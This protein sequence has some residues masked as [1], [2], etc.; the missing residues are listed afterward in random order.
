MKT[1]CVLLLVGISSFASPNRIHAGS[2]DVPVIRIRSGGDTAL[3]ADWRF[4][5]DSTIAAEGAGVDDSGWRLLDL[6]HDW[7]I[8]DLQDGPGGGSIGPFSKESPGGSSTGHTIGGVGWYRKHFSLRGAEGKVVSVLF[9][10]VYMDCDAWINGRHLGGHPYGYTPFFFDLTKGL[11]PEGEDNVLAVRVRNLGRN[12]RWYSGSGIYRHVFLTVKSPVHAARWGIAIST[13]EV[14]Q[15]RAVVTVKTTLENASAMEAKVVIR[16]RFLDPDGKKA[17]QCETRL[18]V[19][20]HGSAESV[21]TVAILKPRLWSP[22]T[23][24]LYRLDVE[25]LSNGKGADRTSQ[26]FGIRSVRFDAADGFLLNGRKTALRGAC[27]HHDNGPL[28]SAAIDRAEERRVEL[29]KAAGF[30]AVRTSH[31]PPSVPFL[32]ACD[33]LGMLVIDEAFDM[34][35][36]PKNPQDYH[37][38]F[39][40]WWQRDLEAMILRDRNHPSVILW[41]IGNE[42]NERADSSGIVIGRR[43][44][45][46]A[47]R[48][49]PTRAVTA[50]ICSFWDHPGR[51]WQDTESAFSIL[52]VGGYNY[53][54]REY[55]PDHE[56]SPQRIMVGT[57]SFPMEAFESWNPVEKNPW[58][59]GDFVW[60]GMDY[61]GEAGIGNVQ[62]VPDS[63]NPQFGMPWP[64]FN[65]FCG[66][67]DL[68]GFK[69]PQ[70]YY[71][72]VVWDR[73]SLEMAV[74]APMAE[75]LVEKPSL[76]GWPDERRS[77]TWP[78]L[79]AK[80]MKVSVYSRCPEVRLELN[81]EPVGEKRISPDSKWT[82]VF[83]VPYSP[84]ILRA[85][86]LVDGKEAVSR[87][88]RTAGPAHRIR[89]IPDRNVIRPD[90]ND[91]SYVTVEIVD[92]SGILVPDS[93]ALVR[94]SVQGDGELAAVGNGNP[95]DMRSFRKPECAVF[96]GKCLA[97]LRP[98]GVTGAIT[99]SA[100]SQGLDPASVVVK[101]R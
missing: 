29:L 59:I 95:R 97:I 34:W 72:D 19:P 99:L 90:R 9:D 28:G 88:L 70:S 4:M 40:D 35:E 42:I 67:I 68:C 93:G 96:Q 31:N 87:S 79:E 37:R 65:A 38:F 76:W 84:G 1:R 18:D 24:S 5:K 30:N 85:S 89:L 21:R 100:E 60:T 101:T 64:W 48:L 17:G 50:A 66:D 56:R 62:A 54:W 15:D 57:E 16:N 46:E 23:P 75:G 45:G 3:D 32:D 58:V 78:G 98:D 55:V 61:L 74:H 47:H 43:L 77:W 44:A 63:V 80:I 14:T 52:D 86:G 13:P 36:R 12:S 2:G 39:A 83:D 7:S 51:P 92:A 6:P 20:A 91:L 10:G 82:A 69:K 49:D 73:S 26:A 71:R 25:I 94:F 81:G 33:R 41:S 11:K 53:Q 8:E 22:E 27:M